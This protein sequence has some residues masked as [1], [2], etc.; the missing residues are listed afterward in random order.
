MGRKQTLRRLRQFYCKCENAEKSEYYINLGHGGSIEEIKAR[1]HQ[2][3]QSAGKEKK[4]EFVQLYYYPVDQSDQEWNRVKNGC[5]ERPEPE[6]MIKR[7]TEDILIGFRRREGHTCRAAYTLVTITIWQA[8]GE[9]AAEEAYVVLSN[10]KGVLESFKR[11]G[12]D[13]VGCQCNEGGGEANTLGCGKAMREPNCSQT[14]RTSKKNSGYKYRLRGEAT[15][16]KRKKADDGIKVANMCADTAKEELEIL[17]EDVYLEMTKFSEVAAACRMGNGPPGTRPFSGSTLVQ[18]KM[19]H[20]H[21]DDRNGGSGLSAMFVFCSEQD[22]NASPQVHTLLNYSLQRKKGRGVGFPLPHMSLHI[23]L[24]GIEPHSSTPCPLNEEG[25]A[26]RIGLILYLHRF[27]NYPEHGKFLRRLHHKLKGIRVKMEKWQSLHMTE[28]TKQAMLE[29]YKQLYEE[30]K[31]SYVQMQQEHGEREDEVGPHGQEV[32]LEDEE[33]VHDEEPEDEEAW[34]L[35][36]LEQ[37]MKDTQEKMEKWQSSH[38][39]QE[40]VEKCKKFLQDANDYLRKRQREQDEG[41]AERHDLGADRQGGG[42]VAGLTCNSC[43]QKF[44]R[45][46]GYLRHV[47]RGKCR[48][49]RAEDDSEADVSPE[50]LDGE[51]EHREPE[52]DDPMKCTFCKKVLS[53]KKCKDRHEENKRCIQNPG[54]WW[55]HYCKR[56]RKKVPKGKRCEHKSEGRERDELEEDVEGGQKHREEEGDE[57]GNELSQVQTWKSSKK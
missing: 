48:K 5:V 7:G 50:V 27:L 2:R 6:D 11:P 31:R 17:A 1:L 24:G 41:D 9:V 29:K 16:E 43:R 57:V 52:E 49:R 30:T 38:T 13:G 10:L 15:K 35:K 42:E 44:T 53:S 47:A 39:E 34:F 46:A 21:T 55:S 28:T 12:T 20:V 4:I 45:E 3:L 51:E 25:R 54:R 19:V 40:K 22:R 56:C 33:E 37:K 14:T 26:R 23:E 8:M 32:Q 36:E 18:S